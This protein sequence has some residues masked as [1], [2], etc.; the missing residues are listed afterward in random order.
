MPD[1]VLFTIERGLLGGVLVSGS[2][3]VLAGAG[4]V[5]EAFMVAT[6]QTV[7]QLSRGAAL[8]F[9]ITEPG[10]DW[11]GGRCQLAWTRHSQ[12]TWRSC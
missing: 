9:K 4:T 7:R 8:L 5:Y 10:G 6:K 12:H 2:L 1:S 3:W 11:R